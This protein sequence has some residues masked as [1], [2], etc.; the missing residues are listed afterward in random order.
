MTFTLAGFEERKGYRTAHITFEAEYGFD[1]S[2][3]AASEEFFSRGTSEDTGEFYFA[4][5]EGMVVEAS[6][7]SKLVETKTQGGEL[8][9]LQLNAGRWA[10]A[11]SNSADHPG[12]TVYAQ[13]RCNLCHR[14]GEAGAPIAS[15]LGG[16]GTRRDVTSLTQFLTN[17]QEATPRATTPAL[18]LSA[19]EAE[20]LAQYLATLK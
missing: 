3:F 19:L 11:R 18:R 14:I 7:T 2:S 4:V 15:N 5:E 10:V 8:V 13:R 1:A 9:L 12:A 16:I 6:I 17:H 20:N